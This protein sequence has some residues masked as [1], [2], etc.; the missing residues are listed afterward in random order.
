MRLQEPNYN[1]FDK[2]L[3][4]QCAL[5]AVDEILNSRPL[6]PNYID[7]DDCGASHQCWYEAQKEEAFVFWVEV[8]N[9]IGNI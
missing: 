3:G 9:E 8:K 6:D 2:R 4:K 7:W 5:I 1:W